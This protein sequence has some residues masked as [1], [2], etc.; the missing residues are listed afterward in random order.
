MMVCKVNNYNNNTTPNINQPD[1]HPVFVDN[2]DL[3]QLIHQYQ[4]VFCDFLPKNLL[5][6]RDIKYAIKTGNV[7]PV[8]INTYLLSKLHIDK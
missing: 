3:R 2:L 1:N 8:N 4:K 5:L 7:K 6:K